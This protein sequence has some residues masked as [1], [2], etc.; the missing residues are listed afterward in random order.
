M[1]RSY[2][3]LGPEG[4][5]EVSTT[6]IYSVKSLT[7]RVVWEC[8]LANLKETDPKLPTNN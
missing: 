2:F 4:V 7:L 5:E 3:V 1:C 8:P 6:M